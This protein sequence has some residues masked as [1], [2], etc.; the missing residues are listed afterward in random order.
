MINEAAVYRIALWHD[1]TEIFSGDINYVFRNF[2]PE[3]C[4]LYEH[5]LKSVSALKFNDMPFGA[6]YIKNCFP[7]ENRK[8]FKLV[9]Y[10]DML[11]L[12]SYCISEYRK[13]NSQM[14]EVI[15]RA[16]Q[17]LQERC[18]GFAVLEDYQNVI[19][20]RIN[21]LLK[22]KYFTIVSRGVKS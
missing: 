16:V 17:I 9:N 14:K 5:T 22:F 11:H 10:C 20:V 15:V 12:L 7:D 13:G 1:V 18:D 21:D 8:E 3:F 2:D 19:E 4:K 6:D